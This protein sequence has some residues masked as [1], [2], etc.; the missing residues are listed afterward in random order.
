MR[1]VP[2][3]ILFQGRRAAAGLSVVERP[4]GR[5]YPGLLR[6]DRLPRLDP[7]GHRA[8]ALKAQ[9]PEFELWSQGMHARSGVTCADCHMPNDEIQ[10]C[11]GERPLGA[12]PGAQYQERLPRLSPEARCQDHRAGAQGSSRRDPG[13]ALEPAPARDDGAGGADRRP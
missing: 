7:Q 4:E 12:Q 11:D 5:E 3:G 1:P 10:G 2:R 13:P 9:H 6:R 8:P